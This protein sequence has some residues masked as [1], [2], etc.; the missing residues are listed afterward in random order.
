MNY[1]GKHRATTRRAPRHLALALALTAGL[2]LPLTHTA[3][4]AHADSLTDAL[5]PELSTNRIHG[6]LTL[7]A[8]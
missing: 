2:T 6:S 4:S 1:V 3:V 8:L 5:H 7:H